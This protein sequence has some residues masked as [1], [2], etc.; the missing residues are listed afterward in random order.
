[1]VTEEFRSILVNTEDHNF[2]IAPMSSLTPEYFVSSQIRVDVRLL[3]GRPRGE[4]II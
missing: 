3:E 1:M 4:T 2:Y